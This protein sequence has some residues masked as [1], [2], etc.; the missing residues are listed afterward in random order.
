M[1]VDDIKEYALSNEDIQQILHPDTKIWTYPELANMESI[2]ECFDELGRCILLYL[3]SDARTGHWVAMLKRGN[4]IEYFDPYGKK[5]DN[6]LSWLTADAKE[7]LDE[8]TS[9][10]Y[11]LLRK[12]KC[13]VNYSTFPYQENTAD[14]NTCGRHCITRLV[15]KDHS[16]EQYH[17]IISRSGLDPDTFV[18]LFTHDILGK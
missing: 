10:L 18:C 7:A 1:S 4:T 5:P 3:T 17:D 11:P 15:L 16:L 9:H 8:S 13:K 12:S 14:V 2:D 6:P